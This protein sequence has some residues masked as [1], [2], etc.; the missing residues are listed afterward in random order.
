ML[1][2]GEP[3]W[4]I[5]ANYIVKEYGADRLAALDHAVDGA[6]DLDQ[7]SGGRPAISASYISR[8]LGRD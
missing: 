7:F 1:M 3:S 5:E 2:E 4:S 8:R 6:G